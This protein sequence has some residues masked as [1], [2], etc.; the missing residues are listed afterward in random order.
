ML[1]HSGDWCGLA[2]NKQNCIELKIKLSPTHTDVDH[3]IMPNLHLAILT[4]VRRDRKDNI[5]W[6]TD[7][8]AWIEKGKS[9][10][11]HVGKLLKQK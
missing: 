3:N 5:G 2:L 11:N 9:S 4:A 10:S 7:E 6:E 8:E 1:G